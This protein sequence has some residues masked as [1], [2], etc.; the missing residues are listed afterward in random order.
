MASLGYPP[1]KLFLLDVIMNENVQGRFPTISR[2]AKMA[3]VARTT[4]R[5]YV[6]QFI[7]EGR[8]RAVERDDGETGYICHGQI[9]P[10]EEEAMRRSQAL[11]TAAAS[12]LS[13]WSG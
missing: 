8:L 5:R 13:K 12:D 3:V 6:V 11:I 9:R 10:Q 2:I 1:D 7:E 4:V